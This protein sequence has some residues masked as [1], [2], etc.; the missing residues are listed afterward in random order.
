MPMQVRALLLAL[1]ALLAAGA[2]AEAAPHGGSSPEWQAAPRLPIPRSEVAA[3]VV[4]DEIV[5]IGG[6]LA[7]GTSSPRVDAYSPRLAR[8]RRLPDLPVAVNHAMAAGHE[9][10]LYVVGGYGQNRT[11]LRSAFVLGRGRWRSLPPLPQP[12]AAAGAAVVGATLVVA[13][14]VGATGLARKSFALDLRTERWSRIPGPTP[15]EHLGVAALDGRIYAVGGR[16]A[17]FD[18]NLD[19]AQVYLPGLRRWQSLPPVPEARGGTALAGLRGLLVSVGGEAPEGTI[20]SVYAFDTALRRWRRLPDL[21]TPR[22]GLGVAALGG[23]VYAIG[24]GVRPGLSVSDANE[25][26]VV[27]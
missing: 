25:T 21:P 6:F 5:V 11:R 27:R 3:A 10:R 14:G 26:L 12:R 9:G 24:G 8:W 22:H 15:R 7:D 2:S 18:T 20:S 23:R 17:G 19:L 13:G 1:I 4:G 16:T